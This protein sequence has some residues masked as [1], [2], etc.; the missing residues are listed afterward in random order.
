MLSTEP[1]QYFVFLLVLYLKEAFGFIFYYGTHLK[2][3]KKKLDHF[4]ANSF[5]IFHRRV[6]KV[7]KIIIIKIDQTMLREFRGTLRVL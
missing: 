7:T 2:K 1:H 3:K 5:D 6:K 4:P